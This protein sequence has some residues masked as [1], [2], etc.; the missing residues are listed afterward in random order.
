[1]S[2]QNRRDR[3]TPRRPPWVTVLAV[4]AGLALGIGVTVA[5]SRSSDNGDR[6]LADLEEPATLNEA[7]QGSPPP[8]ADGSDPRAAVEGFLD[9]EVEQD[10]ASSFGFLSAASRSQY[11]SPE[12]WIAS[13]AD[14]LPV[15]RDYEIEGVEDPDEPGGP[16]EVVALLTF[17]SSLDQ[18]VGLVP[19]RLRVT[20]VTT[21]D[22]GTWGVDLSTST[23]EPLY[24]PEDQAPGAVRQWAEAHQDC[25]PAPSWDG[26]LVGSPALA[27]GLCGTDGE[28]QVGNVLP[29]GQIEASSVLT[30]FGPEAVDWARVVPVTGPLDLRAVVAPIGQQWLVI[31][32]LPA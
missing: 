13:H 27:E 24:P 5:L 19:E 29:L 4:M 1:M 7:A 9:A 3:A 20:W 15:V 8:G 6:Q 21:A 25:G 16:T 22:E 10:F 26:N 28:V 30:A 11:G 23:F 17:E 14:V 18:V 32:V 2:P 31:G 12:R